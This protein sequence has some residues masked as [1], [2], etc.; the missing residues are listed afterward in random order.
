MSAD[1]APKPRAA[2]RGGLRPHS[3]KDGAQLVRTGRHRI[4]E[5]DEQ[6]FLDRLAAS[7]NVSLAAAETG[8]STVAL[9]NRR[10]RDPVFAARWDEAI[11]QAYAR[12]EAL[13][14]DRA[15]RALEGRPPDPDSPIPLMTVGEAIAVL[16]LHRASATGVG[17]RPAW[18]ARPR[19]L[20]ELRG[21]ILAKLSA[22][23]RARKAAPPAPP[24]PDA[25]DPD[26][27]A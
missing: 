6:H 8:F 21:S 10:R 11:A 20:D 27:A 18:P 26:P 25:P 22:F 24:E 16:K 1:S 23:D 13:L 5:A 17:N 14:V 12:I 15:E 19:A 2:G 9:Y 3:G 7:A 4:G